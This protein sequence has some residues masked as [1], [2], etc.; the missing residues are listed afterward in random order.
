M[1]PEEE[2]KVLNRSK[3]LLINIIFGLA[4]VVYINQEDIV[5][6]EPFEVPPSAEVIGWS[7]PILDKDKFSEI[8]ND[9]ISKWTPPFL[10]HLVDTHTHVWASIREESVNL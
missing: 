10:T 5:V 6:I 8:T 9:V 3:T 4:L 1:E 2:T 7:A